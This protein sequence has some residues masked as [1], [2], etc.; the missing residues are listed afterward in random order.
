MRRSCRRRLAARS[1]L[2]PDDAGAEA[3]APH[4]DT[5]RRRTEGGGVPATEG[6][7]MYDLDHHRRVRRLERYA[8]QVREQMRHAA[9]QTEAAFQHGFHIEAHSL[10]LRYKALA[11]Q[12]DA[13]VD[14]LA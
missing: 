6:L 2:R 8:D 10:A 7:L 12:R 3:R 5:R 9:Q 1:R 13:V 4:D 11:D 14:E